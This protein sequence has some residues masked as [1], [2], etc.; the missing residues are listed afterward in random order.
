MYLPQPPGG[1]LVQ[2]V[3]RCLFLKAVHP[4]ARDPLAGAVCPCLNKCLFS[5][6]F[7]F[8]VFCYLEM[9]PGKQ[10][11]ERSPAHHPLFSEIEALMF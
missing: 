4:T 3:S 9:L 11:S 1:A 2:S 7:F 8:N 6:P 10:Y 5:L